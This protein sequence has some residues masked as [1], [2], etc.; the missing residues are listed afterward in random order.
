MKET[1]NEFIAGFSKTAQIE[2]LNEAR[3]Q[4]AGWSRNLCDVS[5]KRIENRGRKWGEKE[6]RIF[7]SFFELDSKD[8]E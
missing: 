7:F 3:E 4:W 8:E 2:D 1:F 6:G 5:R